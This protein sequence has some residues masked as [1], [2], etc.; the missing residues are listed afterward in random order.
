MPEDCC[1]PFVAPS[2]DGV[3]WLSVWPGFGIDVDSSA[4][5]I[6]FSG[7]AAGVSRAVGAAAAPSA[8]GG[9]GA[10][11][12]VSGVAAAGVSRSVGAGWA[13]AAGAVRAP[14]VPVL[15]GES[16]RSPQAKRTDDRARKATIAGV[17]IEG[18]RVVVR[19]AQVEGQRCATGDCSRLDA[20]L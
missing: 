20:L 1:E 2:I 19:H 4:A 14:V 8:C 16:D 3:K 10:W 7:P 5:V 12:W 17:F 13:A 11:A 6:S 18:L 15:I 9:C